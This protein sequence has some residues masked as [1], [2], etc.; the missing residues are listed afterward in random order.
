MIEVRCPMCSHFL[1]E[2]G[3]ET[4]VICGRCK[5]ELT[6]KPSRQILERK[7]TKKPVD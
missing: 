5:S 1:A 6:I 4:R 7:I 3:G 2:V